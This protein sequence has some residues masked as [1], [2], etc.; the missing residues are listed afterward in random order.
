MTCRYSFIKDC[1]ALDSEIR[2]TFASLVT[3]LSSFLE[4]MASYVVL[5]NS[6][7][8]NYSSVGIISSDN[9]QKNRSPA[10]KYEVTDINESSM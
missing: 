4:S 6:G 7:S 10:E 3:R 2:P 1:W 5:N 9:V 8:Q